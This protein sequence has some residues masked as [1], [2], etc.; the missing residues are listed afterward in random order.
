MEDYDD[1]GHDRRAKLITNRLIHIAHA[2]RRCR[3]CLARLRGVERVEKSNL[4]LSVTPP[5]NRHQSRPK[6]LAGARVR[7]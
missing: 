7:A 3:L 5:T 6:S 1:D 4:S 2:R